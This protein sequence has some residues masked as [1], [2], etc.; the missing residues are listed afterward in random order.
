MR[1]GLERE[2]AGRGPSPTKA[3][4]FHRDVAEESR[5]RRV[6]VRRDRLDRRVPRHPRARQGRRAPIRSTF[7]PLGDGTN[8]LPIKA[9]FRQVIDKQEGDTAD[10]AANVAYASLRYEPPQGHIEPSP[11]SSWC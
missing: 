4:T 1:C 9:D 8:K 7:M 10:T 3:I 5:Q 2:A 6:D 11:G